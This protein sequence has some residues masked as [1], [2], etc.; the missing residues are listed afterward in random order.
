MFAGNER[1]L[2][3]LKR[4][5]ALLELA[6]DPSGH[7]SAV[8]LEARVRTCI[9][10]S[11]ALVKKAHELAGIAGQRHLEAERAAWARVMRQPVGDNKGVATLVAEK[12]LQLLEAPCTVG[13]SNLTEKEAHVRSTLLEGLASLCLLA[14]LRCY[15]PTCRLEPTGHLR[16]VPQTFLTSR[17]RPEKHLVR[18]VGASLR[19]VRHALPSR[20][21]SLALSL[22]LSQCLKLFLRIGAAEQIVG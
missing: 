9:R 20:S 19:L 15:G 22:S 8:T 16:G 18:V 11:Q 12:C 1:I 14:K 17:W 4:P 21:L 7:D 6:R 13:S 3:M 2:V 5:A 10:V